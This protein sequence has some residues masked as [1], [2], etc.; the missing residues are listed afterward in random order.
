[1]ECRTTI[2]KSRDRSDVAPLDLM[3]GP[4]LRRNDGTPWARA[5]DGAA[6]STL[7]EFSAVI[8]GAGSTRNALPFIDEG[9]RGLTLTTGCSGRRCAPPLMPSVR[10]RLKYNSSRHSQPVSFGNTPYLFIPNSQCE[11]HFRIEVLGMVNARF[12]K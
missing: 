12:C 1:M 5:L 10:P 7:T 9:L 6:D 4:I 8:R 2:P 11:N 3:R